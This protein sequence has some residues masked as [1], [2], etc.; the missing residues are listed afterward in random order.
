MLTSDVILFYLY[1]LALGQL[2]LLVYI[3][4][5]NLEISLY[6]EF[7]FINELLSFDHI[8]QLVSNNSSKQAM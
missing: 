4:G 5:G 7:Y 6:F 8:L 2:F 1:K 3:F